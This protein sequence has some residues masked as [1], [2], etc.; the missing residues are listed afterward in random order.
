MTSQDAILLG[1]YR[2]FSMLLSFDSFSRKYKID[3]LN[4]L[5][6]MDKKDNEILD[7]DHSEDTPEKLNKD[8]GLE[9]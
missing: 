5:L 8:V 1:V 9:R 2:G 6:N 4:I 7:G 3:E